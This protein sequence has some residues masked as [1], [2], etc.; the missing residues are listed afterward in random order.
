MALSKGGWSVGQHF[1][2]HGESLRIEEIDDDMH[3]DGHGQPHVVALADNGQTY[4]L[5]AD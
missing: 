2:W 3:Y 4:W 1:F 5:S